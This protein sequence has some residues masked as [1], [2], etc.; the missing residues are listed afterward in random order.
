MKK[1]FLLTVFF[2]LLAIGWSIKGNI[3]S[4]SAVT[5]TEVVTQPG[6]PV[7]LIIPKI[8]VQAT[9]E[10][11]GMDYQGRMDIPKNVDNVAWYNLGS[12]P[13][14]I[15]NAVI[16]GHF[17][18]VTGAPAVFYALNT[19]SPGDKIISIDAR[20]EKYTFLV[21]RKK[22][23]LFDKFPLHEVFG[24][25]DKPMLNLITCQGIWNKKTKNYSQ[26]T[27]VYSELLRQK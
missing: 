19:L 16:D 11:V 20:G 8:H 21:V 23:Y 3:H 14:D 25:S 5:K 27:V 18:K 22:D 6:V 12:K 9:V 2:L 7:K 15:G 10:S 17:D 26:R 13:G 1:I 4:R 24:S